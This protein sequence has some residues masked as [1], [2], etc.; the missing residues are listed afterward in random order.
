MQSRLLML[1]GATL[2]VTDFSVVNSGVQTPQKV[3]VSVV[4]KVCQDIPGRNY[5]ENNSFTFGKAS[6]NHRQ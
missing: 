6:S 5:S 1:T 4:D 2:V 3:S